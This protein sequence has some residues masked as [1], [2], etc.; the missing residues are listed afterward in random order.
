M[1]CRFVTGRIVLV[2][3]AVTRLSTSLSV[4]YEQ[5]NSSPSSYTNRVVASDVGTVLISRAHSP[6]QIPQ[7]N[8]RY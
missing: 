2:D 8:Q 1:V 4:L 5:S 7:Q 3:T 6:N